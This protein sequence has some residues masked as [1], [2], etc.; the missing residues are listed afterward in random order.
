MNDPARSR[1]ARQSAENA[2]V[3]V[4][5]EYGDTPEFVV[6]GGLVPELLCAYSD[7]QHAGTTDIDV[8][9]DMEIAS[10]SVNAGRLEHALLAAGFTPTAEHAWRWVTSSA[11]LR[12]EIKFELL[13]DL[14]GERV[15]GI[16]M[17]ADCDDLGACNLRGTGFATR[18]F[19]IRQMTSVVGDA[20]VTVEAY[21]AGLAG[22]LLAKAAAARGRSAPKDWY[23]IAFVLL[24]NDE[25]GVQG[26]IDTVRRKFGGRLAGVRTELAE[27]AANFADRDAQGARAYASQVTLNNPDVDHATAL[28]DGIAAVDE[29]CRGLSSN[30]R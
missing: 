27:L 25:G 15:G 12:T 19:V 8:Q 21:F 22:F 7:M 2:L 13:A 17:F 23:D 9:V 6:L 29:F 24:H 30:P 10:G 3:R 11:G 14:E 26:A 16:I 20:A 1:A 18:D 4:V 5:H 28:T